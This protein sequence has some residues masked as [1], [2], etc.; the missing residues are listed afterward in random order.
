MYLIYYLLVWARKYALKVNQYVSELNPK[1]S[2]ECY[3][4]DTKVFVSS[5]INHFWVNVD[6][7]TR[8]ISATHYSVNS[9]WYE[10]REFINKATKYGTPKFIQTDSAMFYPKV[11]KKLFGRGNRKP[12]VE[13]RT[14][15][16]RR[17]GVHN[18]RIETVFMKI[19]DR[20]DDFRGFKALWSAPIL[21]TG[22]VLQ[23]NY[24]ENHMTTGK[25]PCELAG[26]DLETGF[27]RWLGLIKMSA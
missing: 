16:A 22:I 17:N 3:A 15:N 4:D 25:L 8:F 26:L 7:N 13:H 19:K 27:N 12:L 11:F 9:K 14:T 1:L 20:V 18:V 10:A 5:K 6:W 2:G 21:L 24:I 23:H